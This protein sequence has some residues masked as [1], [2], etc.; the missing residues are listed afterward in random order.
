[1]K[2]LRVEIRS[3]IFIRSSTRIK[4]EDV[5]F[6]MIKQSLTEICHLSFSAFGRGRLHANAPNYS[7]AN[8]RTTNEGSAV[9]VYPGLL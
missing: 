1:M 8:S 4:K 2:A 9:W 6:N 3:S 5:I 7:V